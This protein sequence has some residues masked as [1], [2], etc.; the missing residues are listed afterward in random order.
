[1]KI[2][3][4]EPD[5]ACSM[6]LLKDWIRRMDQVAGWPSPAPPDDLIREEKRLYPRIPC[7]LLVDYATEEW[8]CRA[9]VKNLSADGAF[10]ETPRTLPVETE[11]AL[12]IS[13][14]DD[15]HPVKLVGEVVW[16]GRRGIG[17]KF[18][19]LAECEFDPSVLLE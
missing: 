4:I 12:V 16:E 6:T 2:W 8:A 3:V 5:E 17:V 14:L 15:H 13:F 11:L 1:M 18:D 9:F 10:I 7:F 19:H